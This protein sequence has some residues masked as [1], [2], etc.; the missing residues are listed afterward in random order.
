M[1][2][3]PNE[4]NKPT[5]GALMLAAGIVMGLGATVWLIKQKRD[6]H[7]AWDPEHIINACDAAAAKLDEILCADEQSRRVG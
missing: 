5:T 3:T 6:Q 4:V 2:I 1:K 7:V